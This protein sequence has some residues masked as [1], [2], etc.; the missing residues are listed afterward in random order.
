MPYRCGLDSLIDGYKDRTKGLK[1][2]KSR[3]R[4]GQKKIQSVKN[5]FPGLMIMMMVKMM[6]VIIII[7]IIITTLYG[8]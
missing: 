2:P 6:T 8:S 4:P 3:A 1:Q 7:I 5:L